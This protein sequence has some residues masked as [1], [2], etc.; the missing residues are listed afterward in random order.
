MTDI[1]ATAQAPA[2]DAQVTPG[3]PQANPN[4]VWFRPDYSRAINFL[5]TSRQARYGAPWDAKETEGATVK[6]DAVA[7][8]LASAFADDNPLFD[9]AAF[10]AATQLPVPAIPPAPEG[11]DEPAD[12]DELAAMLA[13][14]EGDDDAE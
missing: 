11:G 5:R 10:L 13:D 4:R 9:A 3:G 7:A 12:P 2:T 8:L 14:E 6:I 1:T